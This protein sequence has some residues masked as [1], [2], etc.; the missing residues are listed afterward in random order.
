MELKRKRTHDSLDS[1]SF[2]HLHSFRCFYNLQFHEDAL[3]KHS[4]SPRSQAPGY[5]GPKG[6]NTDASLPGYRITV[7][8]EIVLTTSPYMSTII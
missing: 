1:P 7:R 3:V 5:T 8:R 4:S 6:R 2:C